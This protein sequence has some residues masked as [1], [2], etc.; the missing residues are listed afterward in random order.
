MNG[1][2]VADKPAT[3]TNAFIGI[4]NQA[5]LIGRQAMTYVARPWMCAHVARPMPAATARAFH[6]AILEYLSYVTEG[7][8]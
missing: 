7:A 2:L 3:D 4:S 5:P 8:L 6:G 1:R